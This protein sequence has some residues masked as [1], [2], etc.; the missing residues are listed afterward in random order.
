METVPSITILATR[1][2]QMVSSD[3][4]RLWLAGFDRGREEKYN[5]S[6]F[7]LTAGAKGDEPTLHA[8]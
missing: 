2:S 3:F 8:D 1:S 7:A 4:R 6:H 5:A